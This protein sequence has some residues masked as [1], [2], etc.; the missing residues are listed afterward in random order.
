MSIILEKIF[1]SCTFPKVLTLILLFNLL[2]KE[3]NLL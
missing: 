3:I 1:Q 2:G